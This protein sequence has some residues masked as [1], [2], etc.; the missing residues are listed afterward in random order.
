MSKILV[1]MLV[2]FVSSC[3]CDETLNVDLIECDANMIEKQNMVLYNGVDT[4][5]TSLI[6]FALD[7]KVY[8][9]LDICNADMLAIPVDCDGK[10]YITVD[11]KIDG[12]IEASK[13]EYFSMNALN[14]GVI[15]ILK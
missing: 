6:K 12:K 10:V 3:V 15:G 5:C 9:V 1:L 7:G 2:V 14:L 11:G 13:Q 4:Y 8:Y